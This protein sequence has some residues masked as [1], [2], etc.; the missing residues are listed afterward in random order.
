MHNSDLP[1][2]ILEVGCG[3]KPEYGGSTRIDLEEHPGVDFVGDALVM[4]Q[5]QPD[6]YFDLVTS[7]H[8]LEHVES[9]ELILEQM[10]RVTA[11]GG[12]ITVTVPHFSNSYF[13]SDPTHKSPWGLYS[14]SY[15]AAD[16]IFTRPT[17][18][19]CQIDGLELISARIGFRSF[20]PRYVRHAL[21]KACLL[22]TS[23]SPRD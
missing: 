5:K 14:M 23:P 22:Y 4:L 8:F 11:P 20:R 18:N 19:Y 12:L 17:P 21:K 6:G 10:V 13:Y 2:E 3:S 15:F 7:R 1:A 9:P 16:A